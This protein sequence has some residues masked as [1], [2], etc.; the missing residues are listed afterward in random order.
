M[1]SSPEPGK[2]EAAA[3][4]RLWRWNLAMA[5]LHGLQGI[6]V[7]IAGLSVTRLRNFKLPL[8]TAFPDW[9]EG[10]PVAAIQV[11]GACR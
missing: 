11:S 5:L 3:L 6:A 1:Q 10:F 8:N 9:S 4:S 7:L 2:D